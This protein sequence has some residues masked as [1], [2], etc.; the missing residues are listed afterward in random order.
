MDG[1]IEAV[2]IA[3]AAVAAALAW[4]WLL[5]RLPKPSEDEIVQMWDERD[6]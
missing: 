2:A 3:G 6:Y 1:L 5:G 4:E